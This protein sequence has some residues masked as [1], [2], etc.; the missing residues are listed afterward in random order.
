MALAVAAGILFI[1]A[2]AGAGLRELVL[3]LVLKG[4]LGAGGALALVVASRVLLVIADVVLAAL[5][6]AIGGRAQ[7]RTEPS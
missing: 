4:D 7:V 6:A 3:V 1:P 5:G 2:P